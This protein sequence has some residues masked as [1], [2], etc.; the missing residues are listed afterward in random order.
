VAAT[1]NGAADIRA[2]LNDPAP[3]SRVLILGYYDGATDGVLEL[4]GRAYRFAMADEG[5]LP[6][7]PGGRAFE[8]RPLP[9]GSLDRIAAALTPYHA[10]GWPVWA[11]LWDFPTAD[12]R[13]AVERAVDEVLSETGPPAWSITTTDTVQF[14]T[15][16]ATPTGSG[17]APSGT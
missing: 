5:R 8:L 6:D 2:G 12:A 9:P 1:T 17:V 11:P 13:L 3:V 15:F 7:G 14:R 4:G 10:P 16:T